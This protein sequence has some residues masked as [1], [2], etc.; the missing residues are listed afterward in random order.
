M[1]NLIYLSNEKFTNKTISY[2]EENTLF[3]DLKSYAFLLKA[4]APA[5]SV[6]QV[7]NLHQKEG[8]VNKVVQQI[9]ALPL[10]SVGVPLDDG[11]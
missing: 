3:L 10:N 9:G 7:S 1:Y 6:P 2:L 5:C 8:A 11:L 4:V